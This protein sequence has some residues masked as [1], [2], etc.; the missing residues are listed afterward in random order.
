[1]HPAVGHGHAL[2][3]AAVPDPGHAVPVEVSVEHAPADD[4]LLGDELVGPT[5]R[6]QGGRVDPRVRVVV[7]GHD[8]VAVGRQVLAEVV[9][10]Q[11]VLHDQTG[12]GGT[13]T[14]QI[15][16]I[17]DANVVDQ[18]GLGAAAVGDTISV[19]RIV[20]GVNSVTLRDLRSGQGGYHRPE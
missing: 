6:G 20:A 19:E 7:V 3:A 18:L 12:G 15:T 8:H 11:F 17:N 16:D 2:A 1:M 4:R 9:D 10:G 5:Q 14:F 13:G